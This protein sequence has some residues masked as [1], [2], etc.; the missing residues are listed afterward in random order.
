LVGIIWLVGESVFFLGIGVRAKGS[1]PVTVQTGLG[2]LNVK[3]SERRL[4]T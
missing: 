4:E 1:R 3:R 2:I